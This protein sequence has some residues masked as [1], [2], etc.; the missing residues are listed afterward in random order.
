[1]TVGKMIY[2][3]GGQWLKT[4]SWYGHGPSY[5][6]LNADMAQPLNDGESLFVEIEVRGDTEINAVNFETV[7]E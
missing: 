3:G 6:H 7:D 5:A 2:G 1:M 4:V